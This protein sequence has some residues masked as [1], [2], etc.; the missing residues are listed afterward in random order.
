[1]VIKCGVIRKRRKIIIIYT[2]EIYRKLIKKIQKYKK[3]KNKI[4]NKIKWDTGN[5]KIKIEII[6]I[7]VKMKI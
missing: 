6:E 4:K 7:K 2:I 3:I 5:S 1:M